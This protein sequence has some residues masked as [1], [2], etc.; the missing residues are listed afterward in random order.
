M[1]INLEGYKH[2]PG[3]E[4]GDPHKFKPIRVWVISDIFT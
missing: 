3:Y 1:P 2:K 4:K